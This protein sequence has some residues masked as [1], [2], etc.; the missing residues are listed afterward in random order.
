MEIAA[1]R[2]VKFQQPRPRYGDTMAKMILHLFLS[3]LM[4]FFVFPSVSGTRALG[5]PESPPPAPEFTSGV[6]AAAHPLA[7][8][9]G[10]GILKKGGNAVDAAVACA[11]TLGVVEPN[12]S[13][14]G[15]GGFMLIYLP[16]LLGA[17][18]VA[19]DYREKAPAAATAA[20]FQKWGEGQMKVGPKSVGVPGTVAGL[21]L[22]LQN[23]GTM[24]LKDVMEPAIQL[25]EQGF[26]VSKLLNSMMATNASK[27][28]PAAAKIYLK[29]GSPLKVGAR[30]YQ[31]DLAE[32]Y[33]L[34]AAQGQEVFYR[35]AIAEA[36]VKQ[37]QR[38]YGLI[39]RED[40]ADYRAVERSPVEGHYRGYEII[41][42]G[43][44]SAGGIQVIELLNILE[45]YDMAR[46]GL[47]SPESIMV[48]F[49]AMNKAFSDRAK[50]LGDPDFVK[51]PLEELLSKEHT[52]KIRKGMKIKPKSQLRGK[53]NRRMLAL[54]ES[55]QTTHFSVADKDGNLVAL[56]QSIDAFF[57][58]GVVVP[59]TG[60][61]LN[62]A[63]GDFSP[64]PDGP[65]SIAPGKRPLSNMSPTLVL[66]NGKPFLAIGT[67][68]GTRIP[69][70]LSQII[71]NLI[72]YHLTLQ[73]AVNAPR[74]HR[75][76]KT[77]E[78]LLESRIPKQVRSVL[79]QKNYP[80]VLKKDFDIYLGG[81]QGVLVD[82]ATGKLSGAADPRREGSVSGY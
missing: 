14:I 48:M 33:R 4:F 46:L 36:I 74:V 50:Y 63:M 64:E 76:T 62:D 3:A 11:F 72:D 15:G 37:M 66:K 82:E 19:I 57:G 23:Y 77:G 40:L 80:V 27:L 47:N 38:S 30:L 45:G 24:A 39:T 41:S 1:L 49:E 22:A 81:A 67:P 25:A 55:D 28:S 17:K 56:S 65:N 68:G 13:G 51:I 2:S 31:K 42:M 43:P 79:A 70:A 61:L 26:P 75:H 6:I 18:V 78:L 7:A 60:I 54:Q 12:A 32:T 53:S 16:K 69:S 21:T 59:G 9:V 71:L 20:K 29:N 52:G 44:P 58:S 8:E 10:A 35:G 5:E 34:I 73:E